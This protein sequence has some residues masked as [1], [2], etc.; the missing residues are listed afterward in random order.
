[1]RRKAQQESKQ[2]CVPCQRYTDFNKNNESYYYELTCE[3]G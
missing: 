2:K 3:K 1:M